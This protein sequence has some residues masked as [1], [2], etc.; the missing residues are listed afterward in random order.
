M[1]TVPYAYVLAQGDEVFGQAVMW[2]ALI[3]TCW[4][5]PSP[6]WNIVSFW[7]ANNKSSMF[8]S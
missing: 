6:P 8:V 7:C 4:Y 3:G 2:V 1:I 5:R